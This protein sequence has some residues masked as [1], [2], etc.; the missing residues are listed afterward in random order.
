LQQTQQQGGSGST[1]T[2]TMNSRQVSATRHGSAGPGAPWPAGN[3]RNPCEDQEFLPAQVNSFTC[4]KSF[5]VSAS[6]C[7]QQQ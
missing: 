4:Q 5:K 6:F 3:R 1:I 2:S 7:L